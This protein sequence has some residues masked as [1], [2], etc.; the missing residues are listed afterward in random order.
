MPTHQ[1]SPEPESRLAITKG[2]AVPYLRSVNTIVALSTPPGSGALGILRLSGDQALTLVQPFFPG[3]KS[4]TPRHAHFAR[5]VLEGDVLDEV[6]AITFPGPN[7]YTGEDVVEL[8]FHGSPFILE[9]ALN[10]LLAQGAQLAKAGEFTQR[11]F[12]NGKL[13]L[14]QAEAV[15]D[16]IASESAS[17]HR[18]AFR[19]MKGS[20]SKRLQAL[21][22]QLIDFAA[23]IELELDFVEE[24]VEF[25]QRPALLNLLSDLEGEIQ[26]MLH[27]FKLGR[28]I[29][30]GIP[31]V[32]A[33]A[34]NAGKST[35][36]N[37]MLDE[38]RAI[39]T[40]IPGTT[41]D[42]IEEKFKLGD[43]V[44]RLIDTAGL[45][46]S[47]DTVERLGIQKSWEKIKEAQF[48]LHLI[49]PQTTE[50]TE[51]QSMLESLRSNAPDAQILT[52]LTK[53]DQWTRDYGKRWPDALCMGEGSSMEPLETRLNHGMVEAGCN[54]ED[55]LIANARHAEALQAAL[56][57]LLKAHAGL[58]GATSGELVAYDLRE[59][60]QHLGSITGEIVA[61]DLLS[62]VFSR[63]C[64]GK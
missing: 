50:V 56:D 62:S 57:A 2:K 26:K 22:Q 9:S 49:D 37:R 54:S 28:A 14:S 7:S 19:Q 25:A 32:L 35:L 12:F 33:G 38:D 53:S 31:L 58:D 52:V 46:D 40:D 3:I 42:T 34:P 24:D 43:H 18:L 27:T 8:S 51:A 23:L 60:L 55:V 64:I 41:R 29:Q 16:L 30:D 13:D 21:R 10:A 6:V 47:T 44:F 5:F 11:A 4:W 45:H 1:G 61:D 48:I 15:G 39:V 20:I 59:A 63:F 36:L 17:A